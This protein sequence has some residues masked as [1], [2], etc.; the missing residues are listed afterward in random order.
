M[1]TIKL[2]MQACI[3]LAFC[4]TYAMAV[5]GDN[6]AILKPLA[7]AAAYGA[8]ACMLVWVADKIATWYEPRRNSDGR[9]T[10]GK[11]VGRVPVDT[12]Q[13][14]GGRADSRAAA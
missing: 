12:G 9:H 6:P 14:G 3:L 2:I 4:A 5:N 10:H 7:D 11:P 1:K 8:G 13:A